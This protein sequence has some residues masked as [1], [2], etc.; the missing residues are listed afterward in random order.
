M[1]KKLTMKFSTRNLTLIAVAGFTTLLLSWNY[2]GLPHFGPSGKLA[3]HH[4]ENGE[5]VND[6]E[7]S[8]L[9]ANA[10]WFTA[11]ESNT[12]GMPVAEDVLV[13]RI[14]GDNNHLLMMAYYSKENY[15][16]K[17]VSLDYDDSKLL[18]RDDGKGDD[19]K[20]GDGLYTA[21]IYADVEA[22]KKQAVEMAFEM[23]KSGLQNYRFV[24]RSMYTD[25]DETTGFDIVKLD[26]FFPVSIAS[27]N[28]F[29]QA[30]NKLDDS[31]RKNSIFITTLSVIEDP[32]RTWN[33]CAQTGNINGAWTFKKLI[34]QLASTRPD[35][36]ANDATV[37]NFVKNWFNSY[38]KDTIINSDTVYKRT[39]VQTK[40]LDPWL[41]KSL[42][43][44]SPAGQLDMKY[45]PFKLTAILNRFDLRERFT[46]IPAGEGRFTFCLI[47][48]DCSAAENFTMVVEYSV[49]MPNKCDSLHTWAQQLYNL[50]NYT[51]GSSAYNQALQAITDQFTLCGTNPK[52][53]NQSCLSTI[54]TNDRSMSEI[55]EFRQFQLSNL[56]HG[57]LENPVTKVP[58]NRY[59]AQ[60]DNA[61]VRRMV[62]YINANRANIN[63]DQYD[64]PPIYLDS[65]FLGGKTSILGPPVGNTIPLNVY[66]WDGTEVKGTPTFI[67]NS[68]TRQVFSLNICSGCHAGEAQTSYTHVDPVNFGTEATLSGFLA[69][70][71][72]QGGAVDFD[73][74]PN[75]DSMIVKDAASRPASNPKLRFFNDIL[76]RARDLKDYVN[77]PCL[78]PLAIRNDLMF[79]P[80]NMVH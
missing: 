9:E 68:T 16:E 64:V 29:T 57:L 2:L 54:R 49:P 73:F 42:A 59:N 69:G 11:P 34:T 48:S 43:G 14:P 25:P 3:V 39:L 47:N 26:K 75:N 28:N 22:F 20:A 5:E 32:T 19:K 10:D 76:R 71:A 40:I 12:K 44:G 63:K 30:G 46:G 24:N 38:L 80:V 35:S 53:I 33:S 79:Q 61:A 1:F 74:N 21:K 52:R 58:A 7:L 51:L 41:A 17:S 8:I 23:K 15:A 72:G 55:A 78:T 77:T 31:L 70:K 56:T 4:W 66:H 27:L 36:I 50:K 65:P 37:S 67:K 45:A 62:D 13:Q 18:F 6:N 60:V